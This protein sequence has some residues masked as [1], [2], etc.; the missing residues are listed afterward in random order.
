LI[1]IAIFKRI[2]LCQVSPLVR[3]WILWT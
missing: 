1:E 2:H 3:L